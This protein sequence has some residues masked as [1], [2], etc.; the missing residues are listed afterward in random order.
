MECEYCGENKASINNNQGDSVCS[1]CEDVSSIK[2]HY[3]MDIATN[4]SQIHNSIYLCNDEECKE[5]YLQS[6]CI[7][8][9]LN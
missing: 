9:I 4:K 2:C 3:C 8:N 1:D 5:N 7:E 6:Y